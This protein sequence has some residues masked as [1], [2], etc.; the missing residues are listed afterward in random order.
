MS[1]IIWDKPAA[2]TDAVVTANLNSLANGNAVTLANAVE[3]NNESSLY[4]VALV[5]LALASLNVSA[6]AAFVPIYCVPSVDGTNY[7]DVAAT[8]NIPAAEHLKRAIQF[9]VKNGVQRAVSHPF[10]IPPVKFKLIPQNALG[11]NFASSGNTFKV[12]F[13]SLETV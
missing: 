13:G 10:S 9:V 3:F 6:A 7:P 11:V 2:I 5:E 4:T 12:R 1:R 8:T